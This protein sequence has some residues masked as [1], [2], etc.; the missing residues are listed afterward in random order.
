[1]LNYKFTDANNQQP[2]LM[3]NLNNQP[4]NIK[5]NYTISLILFLLIINSVNGQNGECDFGCTVVLESVDCNNLTAEQ[6]NSPCYKEACCKVRKAA[7]KRAAAKENKPKKSSKAKE[8]KKTLNVSGSS[9]GN[10][11]SNEFENDEDSSEN[12]SSY[13]IES[14]LRNSYNQLVS[15]ANRMRANGQAGTPAYNRTMESIRSL[16]NRLGLSGSNSYSS[17]ALTQDMANNVVGL[18][19]SIPEADAYTQ[20]I[21]LTY[22]LNYVNNINLVYSSGWVWGNIFLDMKFA[23][24]IVPTKGWEYVEEIDAVSTS[25]LR[26]YAIDNNADPRDLFEGTSRNY[27]Y[28]KYNEN[29]LGFGGGMGLALGFTFPIANKFILKTSGAAD[30]EVTTNYGKVAYGFQADFSIGKW[31]LGLG[32]QTSEYDV[33]GDFTISDSKVIYEDPDLMFNTN[34][35]NEVNILN[36][37]PLEY[38]IKNHF[39]LRLAYAL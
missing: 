36:D 24:V 21:G 28:Y 22:S 14:S 4:M 5:S 33:G 34:N 38:K 13:N 31:I 37:R 32:Y 8:T 35:S 17:Q 10:S 7:E 18:L 9:G 25:D 2:F 6:A 15:S 23:G 19:N 1:V 29:L 20:S 16:E 12:E 27:T 11:N 39:V 3:K 30:I 26:N